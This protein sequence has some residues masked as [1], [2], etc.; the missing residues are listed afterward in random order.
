MA[1][2]AALEVTAATVFPERTGLPPVAIPALVAVA[3]DAAGARQLREALAE[4][5]ASVAPD[6]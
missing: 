5:A 4:T 6:T 3:E 2:M 1:A